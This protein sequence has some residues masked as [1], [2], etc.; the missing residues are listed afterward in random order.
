MNSLLWATAYSLLDFAK[1]LLFIMV[2]RCV[3]IYKKRITIP[4]WVAVSLAICLGYYSVH[5]K[6]DLFLLLPN[7]CSLLLVFIMKEKNKLVCI[8]D[9]LISWVI[10]DT[11]S[12]LTIHTMTLISGN[13]DLVIDV[14]S[15]NTLV[16]KIIV[17]FIP[18]IYHIVVNLCIKKKSDYSLYPMQWIVVLVFGIGILIIVPTLDRIVCG[19]SVSE[20]DYSVMSISILILLFLFV[21]V[22]LWQ[23]YVMRKNASLR[24]NEMRYQ[25]MLK[26]QSEHFDNLVKND[27]E[28]RK[29][30]HDMRAHITVLREYASENHDE[31]ILEYLSGMEEKANATGAKRFTGNR[32]VDAVIYDQLRSM[33]EKGIEFE[34]DGICR[35]RDDISD[36]DLCTIFYNLLKNAIEGCEKVDGAKKRITVKVKNM[37]DKLGISI[38]NDTVLKEIPVDGILKTTKTDKINH[39][40]GTRSVRDTVARYDG[41]Y[42]NS[43][44]DGRFVADAIL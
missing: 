19:M 9:V 16:S 6:E 41:V 3:P 23:S 34:Y 25:Y 39:G 4:I 17:I 43:I 28:I 42:V 29:F 15:V 11:L 31:K 18:F 14:I 37:G 20:K 35:S 2:I 22:M 13:Y 26:S 30:R 5:Q 1:Y 7:F 10:M 33:D 8:L 40:L 24:R 21:L 38:G 12:E 27:E 32:A 44:I 36:I